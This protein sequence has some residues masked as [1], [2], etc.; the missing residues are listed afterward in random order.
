MRTFLTTHDIDQLK[1]MYAQRPA[2]SWKASNRLRIFPAATLLEGDD[3]ERFQE[4][5]QQVTQLLEQMTKVL[6]D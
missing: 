3:L 6:G 4:V 5:H 1:L 2:L